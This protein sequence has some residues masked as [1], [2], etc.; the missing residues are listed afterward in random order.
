M[1]A[2]SVNIGATVH[3]SYALTGATATSGGTVTYTAYTDNACSLGARDAGNEGTST[4]R[5][6]ADSDG[7]QFNSAG[8]FYWQAVYSGDAANNARKCQ[9][10]WIGPE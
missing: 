2:G 1:S 7:L 4:Y 6:P 9:C 3:D 5:V 10:W 8:T